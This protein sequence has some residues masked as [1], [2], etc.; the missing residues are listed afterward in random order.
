MS[1]RVMILDQDDI[2]NIQRIL[3][4]CADHFKKEVSIKVEPSFNELNL[5]AAL[6]SMKMRSWTFGEIH[7][8]HDVNVLK[9]ETDE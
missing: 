8:L 4:D 9:G 1:K 5:I 2:G 7:E 6:D 3:R